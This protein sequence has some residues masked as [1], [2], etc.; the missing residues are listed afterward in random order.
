MNKPLFY[1][2]LGFFGIEATAFLGYFM[3]VSSHSLE[4]AKF[5]I[6]GGINLVFAIGLLVGA[7]R[8]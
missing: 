3:T 1:T 5:L 8:E 7:L 2:S 4:I 6:F